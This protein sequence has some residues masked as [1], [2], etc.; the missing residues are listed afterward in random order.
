MSDTPNTG[1]PYVPEGTLDPAA[2]LNLSLNVIDALLQTAVIELGLNTPPVSPADG[3]L[4]VVGVGTGAWAGEDDNVA[5]YV[6]DG[7]FWQ[8]YTAGVNAWIVFNRNDNGLYVWMG[9]SLGWQPAIAGG[10]P[11]TL[12]D[13]TD[14]D[15]S[16]SSSA[17]DAGDIL[18]HD[19]VSF[20]LARLSYDMGVFI[21][22]DP[23]SDEVVLRHVVLKD[24]TI[25]AGATGSYSSAIT[26]STGTAVIDLQK[27]SVSFG[28]VTF[29]ASTTGVIAVAS[30][31]SFVPGDVIQFVAPSTADATLADISISLAGVR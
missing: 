18:V 17:A 19:G 26:A 30:D 16:V 21:A 6:A 27:N 8:F 2:G 31:T 4:Y 15:A 20:N 12:S 7:D 23:A 11:T 13:L 3:D 10:V 25:P 9:G 24:F 1:I 29:T 22:G 14:V 5:R 28:T